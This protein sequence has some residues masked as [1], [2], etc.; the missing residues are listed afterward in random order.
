MNKLH[1]SLNLQLFGDN[2]EKTPSDILLERLDNLEKDIENLK[3]ENKEITELNRA[4]L[5]R[6]RPAEKSQDED[7][8]SAQAKL[9]KYLEEY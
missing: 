6:N 5:N 8:N 3:K 4:L 1:Y 2:E 7:T 9:K